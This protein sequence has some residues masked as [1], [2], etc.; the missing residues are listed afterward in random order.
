M[1]APRQALAWS[2]ELFE[3][4]GQLGAVLCDLR[5]FD[6]AIACYER[7]LALAPASPGLHRAIGRARFAQGRFEESRAAFARALELEPARYDRLLVRKRVADF[8]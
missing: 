6:E 1:R 5:Q 2:P 4:L 7:A 3:L 8:P